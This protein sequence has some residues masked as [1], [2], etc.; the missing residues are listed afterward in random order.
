MSR[1]NFINI[2]KSVF[3]GVFIG[4]CLHLYAG[5][6]NTF[7]EWL[8]IAL[9]SGIIGFVI[10][11]ITEVAT[12]FLPV[13]IARPKVYFLINGL[14]AV[15]VAAI[16]F[17][18]INRFFGTKSMTNDDILK[19]VLIIMIMNLANIL[20][21]FMYKRANKKLKMYKERIEE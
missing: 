21:Y 11:G 15:V 18:L 17:L 14:I 16:V 19:F 7:G 3:L 1:V 2:I 9:I 8:Y 4:I 12:A 10:G 20:D 13:S 6:H 5:S